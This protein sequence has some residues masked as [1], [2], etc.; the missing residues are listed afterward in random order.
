MKSAVA[1]LTYGH[2]V[3]CPTNFTSHLYCEDATMMQTKTIFCSGL[4]EEEETNDYEEQ[5]RSEIEY[6]LL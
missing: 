5:K 4:T 1:L 2:P 6:N 3:N